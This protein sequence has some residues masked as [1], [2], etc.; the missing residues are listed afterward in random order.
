MNEM[1]LVK[2]L[3]GQL[4]EMIAAFEQRHGCRP[5]VIF[6]PPMLA[7]T[8]IEEMTCCKLPDNAMP[9]FKVWL[10]GLLVMANPMVETME[11]AALELPRDCQPAP[12]EPVPQPRV[13]H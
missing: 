7:Q 1:R 8:V 12:D 3:N 2:E 13:L 6:M 10:A 9:D 5:T 11:L 4:G